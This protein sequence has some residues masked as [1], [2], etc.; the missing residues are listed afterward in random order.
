ML[1][2]APPIYTLRFVFIDP[3]AFTSD[4]IGRLAIDFSLGS[5]EYS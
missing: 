2:S 1:V 3:P 5:P 4:N